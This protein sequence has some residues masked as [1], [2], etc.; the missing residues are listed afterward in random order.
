MNHF[1]LPITAIIGRIHMKQS[2]IK[3]K[4]IVQY[5]L[6]GYNKKHIS[7]NEEHVEFLNKKKAEDMDYV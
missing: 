2:D 6:M 1:K 5:S 3:T 7:K 4:L